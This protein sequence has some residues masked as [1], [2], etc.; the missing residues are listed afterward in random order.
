MGRGPRAEVPSD[1]RGGH[2]DMDVRLYVRRG[3]SLMGKM[4]RVAHGSVMISYPA[5][6][7]SDGRMAAAARDEI[8]RCG[9][10]SFSLSLKEASLPLDANSVGSSRHGVLVERPLCSLSA[11][12]FCC[13]YE[14]RRRGSVIP[15]GQIEMTRPTSSEDAVCPGAVLHIISLKILRICGCPDVIVRKRAPRRQRA[16]AACC[17]WRW[18]GKK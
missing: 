10:K 15:V 1:R 11:E 13:G 12:R 7:V 2:V 16:G 8:R 9:C 14:A 4:S 18:Q 3:L 17:S 5:S 6:L